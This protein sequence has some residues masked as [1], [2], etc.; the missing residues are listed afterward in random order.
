[1]RK[2]PWWV[3]VALLGVALLE[4]SFAYTALTGR[5]LTSNTDA[6]G[7]GRLI[8]AIGFLLILFFVYDSFK[9]QRRIRRR[10]AELV[11]KQNRKREEDEEP[12]TISYSEGEKP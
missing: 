11:E 5:S 4:V 7:F 1:M 10:L 9:R 6:N 2:F 3:V 8:A 12:P